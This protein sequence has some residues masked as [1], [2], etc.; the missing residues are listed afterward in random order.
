[1][2]K[3]GAIYEGKYLQGT[4]I[5]RPVI[6][7]RLVEV[8]LAEKQMPLFTVVLAKVMTRYG[9]SLRPKLWHHS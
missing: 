6:A 3:A 2:V 5:A 1:M 4:S 7:K 9:L 8:A